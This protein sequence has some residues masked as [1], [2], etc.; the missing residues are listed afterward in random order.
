MLEEYVPEIKYIKGPDNDAS[1]AFSKLLLIN[2]DA[3][4]S[5]VTRE[6]LAERYGV[7]QLDGDTL[8]LTHQTINKYQRKDKNW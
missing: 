5:G 1:D 6:Q 3:I 4:E 8:P 7:N 2:S